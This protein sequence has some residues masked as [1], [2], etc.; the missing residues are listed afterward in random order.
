MMGWS[1]DEFED[2][3][4]YVVDEIWA[5]ME[6]ERREQERLRRKRR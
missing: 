4:D 2:A 5:V 3:P 1:W 6:E